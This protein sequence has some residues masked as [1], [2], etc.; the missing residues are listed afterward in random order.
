MICKRSNVKLI[1]SRIVRKER[2][3]EKNLVSDFDAV[4]DANHVEFVPAVP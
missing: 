4:V 1:E 2:E 3:E